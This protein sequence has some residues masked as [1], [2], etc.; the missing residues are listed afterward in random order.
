MVAIV[1][2]W[3]IWTGSWAI[4]LVGVVLTAACSLEPEPTGTTP[5]D[6]E[7][8]PDRVTTT[9]AAQPGS[10][11][12]TRQPGRLTP[13]AAR[14]AELE[15]IVAQHLLQSFTALHDGDE[16]GFRATLYDDFAWDNVD[17]ERALSSELGLSG[18]PSMPEVT[19]GT[20]HL[21]QGDCFVADIE[22]QIPERSQSDE[23][24]GA[25]FRRTPSGEWTRAS[26][27]R[28]WNCPM[29]LPTERRTS[30]ELRIGDAVLRWYRARANQNVSELRGAH[31]LNVELFEAVRDQVL[32]TQGIVVGSDPHVAVRVSDVLVDTDSCL[33]AHANLE[34]ESIFQVDGSSRTLLSPQFLTVGLGR[35]AIWGFDGSWEPTK[36]EWSCHG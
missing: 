16:A 8:P 12:E 28:Q 32:T 15:D 24:P 17:G 6:P 4:L 10:T 29:S 5:Y 30:A 26:R 13:D 14:K 36:R 7:A 21:D 2:R 27:N 9:T 22:F 35:A 18:P 23:W 11:L 1:R 19:I 25:T 3:G 31:G 33:V 34:Y 20:I